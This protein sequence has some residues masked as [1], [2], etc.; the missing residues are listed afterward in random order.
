MAFKFK[1]LSSRGVVLMITMDLIPLSF[2]VAISVLQSNLKHRMDLIYLIWAFG[3]IADFITL[4]VIDGGNV[5][6][7]T[8]IQPDDL[9]QILS[10]KTYTEQLSSDP[11]DRMKILTLTAFA[12]GGSQLF[13]SRNGV[14]MP[15]LFVSFDYNFSDFLV[16][17]MGILIIFFLMRCYVAAST[18]ICIFKDD[19]KD[20][21][22][23]RV[24]ILIGL[25]KLLHVF[26][27]AILFLVLNLL[28]RCI[29][30][31][32]DNFNRFPG[33]GFYFDFGMITGYQFSLWRSLPYP[34]QD[35]F[36]NF[37]RPWVA[38]QTMASTPPPGLYSIP[39]YMSGTS[40][41]HVPLIQPDV[42]F[43]VALGLFNLFLLFM[44]WTNRG[45]DIY[46]RNQDPV[47]ESMPLFK[48]IFFTNNS[49]I[50]TMNA[51]IFFAI[52]P[53]DVRYLNILCKMIVI[54]STT[55]IQVL[56]D[57]SQ[58]ISGYQRSFT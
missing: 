31:I 40:L 49:I 43:C 19:S 28:K 11:F 36:T 33:T 4:I 10:K 51:A 5:W 46:Q 17:M 18:N 23:K 41:L 20:A 2:Y 52:A 30:D 14:G 3:I 16:G 13:P 55:F 47:D 38:N 56:W 42:V 21:M 44:H 57:D 25:Q 15:D 27:H 7:R 54:T 35:T 22:S 9:S 12:W 6:T 37:L 26:I 53:I 24:N 8:N 32:W 58:R 34:T 50:K 29:K 39:S 45:I 48:S 1:R